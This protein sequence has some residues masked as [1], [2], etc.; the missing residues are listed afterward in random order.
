MI[1][2]TKEQTLKAHRQL[3]E[4]FGGTDGLRDNNLL[5]S[6]LAAPFHAFGE[7][8]AFPTIEQK[9]AR[10]AFGLIKNHP[11]VDGNKRI[12]AHLMLAFLRGNNVTI[13]YTQVELHTIINHVA[14]GEGDC[15]ELLEWI[16]EHKK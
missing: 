3:I 11:F 2:I 4:K 1:R 10:L 16:I 12:G 13:K 6:A 8:Y 5:E 7:D 9:A 14:S 15:D